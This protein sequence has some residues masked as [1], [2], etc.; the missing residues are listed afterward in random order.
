MPT[1]SNKLAFNVLWVLG[2]LLLIG[3][4]LFTDGN[5]GG[6]DSVLHYLYAKYAFQHPEN[7]LNHWAKPFFTLLASPFTLL[8]F[9]GIK[10]FNVVCSSSSVWF[11]YKLLELW[12]VPNRWVIAPVLFS[13]TLFI[14]VTLSGLTEP[15]SALL[16]IS[17]VY[18]LSNQ[19]N[20]IGLI[21][22]SFMPL[23]RSEG[24][25]ILG[26]FLTYL[27]L[28]KNF[29]QVPLLLTGQLIYSIGGYPYYNDLMWIFTKIPYANSSANYGHGNWNH[30][31]IQLNFQTNP[32]IYSLFWLGCVGFLLS[33]LTNYKI[34][35]TKKGFKE[36]LW[37]VYGCFFAFLVAHSSFWALGIFNSMGLV[38]VFV[39]VMPLLGIIVIDGL[40]FID[41]SKFNSK[42]QQ[43][44]N[45]LTCTLTLAV[46]VIPFTE[47][48]YGYNF[49]TDFSLNEQQ[50]IIK[51]EL[52]PFLDHN[53][54]DT[55]I[56]FTDPNI[57]FILKVD[58]FDTKVCDWYYS[59][60]NALVLK[61]T[62]LLIAD[63]WFSKIEWGHPIE[64]LLSN[65]Q[66]KLQA[67][68]PK[69]NP[70]FYVFSSSKIKQ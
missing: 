54:A 7:L 26:V 30:F 27:I 50:K 9:T 41:V 17:S 35:V 52:K 37:L 6:G 13:I 62:D 1:I 19:K 43:G 18:F 55:K 40:N 68:F 53:F 28:K 29:K 61:Q 21:I 25:I 15:L 65:H 66:L 23:V 22:I 42:Y 16:L 51:N 38:R 20:T 48:K 70:T 49:S 24:L 69:L 11:A 39:S 8:D 60:N 64:E 36:K 33:I 32:I 56:I 4:A 31:I 57:P 2:T 5:G 63:K 47:G 44:A 34:V 46:M 12:D 14:T 3:L 58:P 45:L 67:S 10:L 59:I